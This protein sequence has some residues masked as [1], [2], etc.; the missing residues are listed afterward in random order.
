MITG[1]D[2]AIS[3]LTT[4]F[5]RIE[6]AITD[7]IIK[8]GQRIENDASRLASGIGFFDPSGNWV[9]LNGKV[10]G[11]SFEGGNGYRIWVDAGKMGAYIE[12][13]TGEYA[14]YT[15]GGYTPEWQE[16]AYTFYVNGKG[17]LPARPYMHPAFAKN[18]TGLLDRLRRAIR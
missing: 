7:E 17:K 1:L 5:V 12:F 16:L 4:K 8:T 18:T 9:M 11:T 14:G 2:Q 6:N 10:K 3:R 15:V 13:G